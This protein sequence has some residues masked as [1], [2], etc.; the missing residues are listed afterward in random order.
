MKGLSKAISVLLIIGAVLGFYGSATSITDVL[1]C[2]AYWE[3]E[4]KKTDEN[5]SLLEDGVGQLKE[6]EQ[7]YTDGVTQVA[8]GEKTLASGKAEFA[9][10]KVA[11]AE[12]EAKLAAGKQEYAAGAASLESL[13]TLIAGITQ[14]GTKTAALPETLQQYSTAGTIAACFV[15]ATT[16]QAQGEYGYCYY[17]LKTL[18]ATGAEETE[19]TMDK[20]DSLLDYLEAAGS[21]SSAQNEALSASMA[22]LKAGIEALD[23]ISDTTTMDTLVATINYKNPPTVPAS[24]NETFYA[25]ATGIYEGLVTSLT[26]VDPETGATGQQALAAGI[27]QIV[28]GMLTNEEMTAGLTQA[29]TAAGIDL[30]KT[31]LTDF[32]DLTKSPIMAEL[33]SNTVDVSKY[34]AQMSG[35]LTGMMN[36]EGGLKDKY[37][38]GA[39]QLAAA[40]KQL[41]EG[42]ATLAASAVKLK[43]AEKQLAD[44]EAQLVDGK[45]KLAQYE[46]GEKT[47]AGGLDQLLAAETYTGLKSIADRL[48]ADFSY[49]KANNKNV[50]LTKAATAVQTGR[51]F[52]ADSSVKITAELTTR[53]YGN[54][55]IIGAG[56]FAIIAAI[57]AFLKKR[58]GAGACAIISAIAAG[59]GIYMINSAGTEMSAI[60]GSTIAGFGTI[61]G[62]VIIA[63]LAVIAAIAYFS[64]KA[65][66]KA[67]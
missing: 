48:G 64:A 19:S 56:V 4:G 59:V 23:S 1:D 54:G 27:A 7:A 34:I 24:L 3:E 21:I 11:F 55:A 29:A 44:G 28:G 33:P 14:L 50:D 62:G 67:E 10:G 26:A 15:Q 38:A 16:F 41:D 35:A 45:K 25:F 30:T 40:K 47:L 6:N 61:Y 52:S 13:G 37:A 18:V 58:K 51:D 42:E 39:E 46:D 49:L 22:S 12:G 66:T 43:D 31:P 20:V 57:L 63:A 5:L 36:A 53:A 60:A 17:F 32:A 9:A 65:E 2:K 8:D